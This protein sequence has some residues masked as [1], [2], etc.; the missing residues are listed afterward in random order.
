MMMDEYLRRV[1]TALRN[2]LEITTCSP[3]FDRLLIE[4]GKVYVLMHRSFSFLSILCFEKSEP[5][6][7]ELELLM[8]W[9]SKW[10]DI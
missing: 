4:Q 5:E 10:M 3:D 7:V 1:S 6:F 8:K 9:E 2:S